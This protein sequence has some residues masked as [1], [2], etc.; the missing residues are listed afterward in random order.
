M[1]FGGGPKTGS[2]MKAY[3]ND[4]T[5]A[6]PVWEEVADIGDLSLPDISLNIAELKRRS[7]SWTK[8]LAALY[9]MY[10][11]EFRLVHGLTKQKFEE[12]LDDFTGPRVKEW[13]V[14]DDAIATTGT[15][16]IRIPCLIENFPWDQ[17]LEDVSGH[18]IRLVLAWMEEASAEVDPA[19]IE[20]GGTPGS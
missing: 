19:W 17:P 7:N 20:T 5:V 13:A 14:C 4:G 10:A 18:D 15:Y 12:I 16:G 9:S 3:R 11:I 6:T 1:S 8:G 2:K